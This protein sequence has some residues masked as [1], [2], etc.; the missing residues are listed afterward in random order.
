M[1]PGGRILWEAQEVPICLVLLMSVNSQTITYSPSSA[2]FFSLSPHSFSS[3]PSGLLGLGLLKTS[4]GYLLDFYD[5]F[6]C[7][8]KRCKKFA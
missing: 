6:L 2:L 4:L 5:T 7:I 3:S 8:Q 1:W